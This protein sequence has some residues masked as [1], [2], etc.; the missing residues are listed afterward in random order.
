MTGAPAARHP[1]GK[2]LQIVCVRISEKTRELEEIEGGQNKQTRNA[3]EV[4]RERKR[5][6]KK[7][8]EMTYLV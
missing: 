1:S 5:G 6:E 4:Q 8:E 3:E 2:S 7:K